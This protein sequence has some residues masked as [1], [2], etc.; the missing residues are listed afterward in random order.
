MA[1]PVSYQID[2]VQYVAVLA[3]IGGSLGL[4]FMRFECLFYLFF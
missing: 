2:G 4:N 3:G 1:P